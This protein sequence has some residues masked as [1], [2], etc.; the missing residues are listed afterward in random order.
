MSSHTQSAKDQKTAIAPMLSV[1]K[2]A[3]AVEFYK[4]AFGADELFCNV[5]PL[6]CTVELPVI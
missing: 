3:S 1:R 4:R 2:G 6:S 5:Q